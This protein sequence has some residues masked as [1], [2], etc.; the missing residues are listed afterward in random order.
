[1]GPTLAATFSGSTLLRS[2]TASGIVAG[3]AS[4]PSSTCSASLAGI[5]SLR[6]QLPLDQRWQLRRPAVGRPRRIAPLRP[7]HRRHQ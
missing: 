7:L 1:V 2:T 6:S 4:I 3:D 5:A